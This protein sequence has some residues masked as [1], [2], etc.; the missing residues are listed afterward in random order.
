M[1][2]GDTDTTSH[3]IV[4]TDLLDLQARLRGDPASLT[5]PR[6]GRPGEGDGVVRLL[7]DADR[8]AT[9]IESLRRRLVALELEIRAYESLLRDVR[10]VL[11]APEATVIDLQERRRRGTPPA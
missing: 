7:H 4:L 2:A 3:R 8:S 11:P 6:T 10:P 5:S 1:R 9:R